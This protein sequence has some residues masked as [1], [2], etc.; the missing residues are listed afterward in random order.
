MGLL[1]ECVDACACVCHLLIII[2]AQ[3]METNSADM[4]EAGE[5]LSKF[6][7]VAAKGKGM[8]E[9]SR[10]YVRPIAVRYL[11]KHQ[12]HLFAIQAMRRS[13]DAVEVEPVQ[14][15]TVTA[16]QTNDLFVDNDWNTEIEGV[17]VQEIDGAWRSATLFRHKTNRDHVCIWF[18][19]VEYEGLD[20]S[21]PYFY[22]SRSETLEDDEGCDINWRIT[23]VDNDSD[24]D[25][26]GD[27]DD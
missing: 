18:G 15:P 22:D 25:S 12:Q 14:I 11:Q 21:H 9:R 26:D 6:V 24:S 1:L 16:P 3:M 17:E 23:G 8:A 2:L 7:Q 4:L 20:P 5:S 13:P 19:G 10:G 27:V